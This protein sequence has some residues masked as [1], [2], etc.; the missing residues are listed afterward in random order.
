MRFNPEEGFVSKLSVSIRWTAAVVSVS[1]IVLAGVAMLFSVPAHH[2]GSTAV[3]SASRSVTSEAR[4]RALQKL[5]ELPLA[6]EKNEGQVDSQVKYMARGSGYKL[7]LT[8][9]DAVLTFASSTPKRIS[10]PRQI[11]EQRLF[12]HGRKKH[13]LDRSTALA[14]NGSADA[15]SFPFLRMHL[16][17][18]NP[19][20]K[21]EGR[22]LLASK[23]NY[24]IGNDPHNWHAGVREFGRVSYSAVYP[25][26]DLVYHGQ[27]KQLE[28][29]FVVSPH[30]QAEN[31]AMSFAGAQHIAMNEAGDLVLTL[32][33]GEIKLHR[34]VA[35]Q[36]TVRGREI[37]DSRFVLDARNEVRVALGDYDHNR[38][39][40]IDPALDYATY[41]GGNGDDEA[42]GIALDSG[43]NIYIT[44]ESDS[45]S[46]FPLSN[47]PDNGVYESFVVKI[48]SAENPNS[49]GVPLFTTFVGGSTGDALGAAIAVTNSATPSVYVAG[50]T[51][52]TNLPTTAGVIQPNSGSPAKS[53]CSTSETTNTP[54][55]DGFVFQ[56]NASGAVTYL[57]YLG[58]SNDDGA[59]GIAVDGSGNAYVTGFT[60]SS[61][62]PLSASP[63][64]SQLNGGVASNPPY[65]DAF[66]SVVNPTGTAFV[67]STYLGGAN[68]D[69]GS[70]I[71]VDGSGNAYI[72]GGTYSGGSAST[73]F[74]TTAGAYQTQCGGAPG[75]CNAGN[76]LIFSDVFI[77][78]IA[79]GGTA[80]TYSTFLGGSSDDL[81]IAV[82]LDGLDNIYVTGQTL[83]DNTS[84]TTDNFPTTAGSF[85]PN[86]GGGSGN[87]SA[88]SN[89]FVSEINPGGNGSADL[90]YSSFLGG[91]N[92]DAGL[93]IVSD[94]GGNAFVTGSTLSSD[95]PTAN[96][97]QASLNGNSDAFVTEVATGGG[98]LVFSSYLGGSGDENFDST[99]QAFLGGAVV[100]DSQQNMYLAGSTSSLD[101]PLVSAWEGTYGGGPF[102]AFVATFST[103]ADFSIA[104]NGLS[105]AYVNPGS[106]ATTAVTIGS[107]NSFTGSVALSC[108]VFSQPVNAISPPTC[109]FSSVTVTGG[110]GKST[111]TVST[112][113]TTSLGTYQVSVLGTGPNTSH[114]IPV[115]LIVAPISFTLT[116]TGPTSSVTPGSSANIAV[117]LAS[118]NYG[119]PVKL[120][121]SV[122]G[123]GS[124]TPACG[125]FSPTSPIT[126]TATGASTT[127]TITTTGSSAAVMRPSQYLYAMWLP[128]A[129][130]SI[131][132]M[133]FSTARSRRR[134]LLG[135]LAVA[136][137]MLA[138]FLIPACSKGSNTSNN[139]GGG[140]ESGC[141]GCTPAGSYTVTITGA[142]T[143]AQQVT[144][145][146]TVNLTV[147]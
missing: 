88:L 104:T 27:K 127:L 132:G 24:F 10:R 46:G 91:S 31:I 67:Y 95:F 118:T 54:C 145:T 62:F 102:D 49:G 82:S 94:S 58:G 7:F 76:G 72:T 93:G 33:A 8:S 68:N 147:N 59:F 77:S 126:P 83:Y 105:P 89:G 138:L 125:S 42:Y 117:T 79:A 143:D 66:V 139:G 134:K 101:F 63:L 110:S 71:A 74:P 6:F 98:S 13:R 114:A 61:N 28:F 50:I 34:P 39:L 19:E 65:E 53:N 1:I 57:T 52:A 18:G 103:A 135:L 130:L 146:A 144:Q 25:G 14:S 116:A 107:L 124:P 85:E 60:F 142:G 90:L 64:Y 78:K 5:A 129:G 44:G 96:P 2:A 11:M 100:L 20:A 43:G 23:T 108:T 141:T 92:E 45:T 73:A 111:L 3:S 35:Y 36:E 70:G 122:S 4:T 80:L 136:M 26:I 112:T 32:S 123:T 121:C 38:E 16:V 81:G 99:D 86:Y 15:S 37:V 17:N 30:A 51:T 140:N 48:S 75:N 113:A 12:G 120:S 41:I 84:S 97:Y 137:V 128:I 40:V 55:T 22:D 133:S 56:L 47:P 106:S 119:F 29:D 87:N 115:T 109:S 69:F 21:V 131:L 9:S